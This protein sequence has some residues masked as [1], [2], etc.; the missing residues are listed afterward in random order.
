MSLQ[1]L[2][3]AALLVGGIA[4]LTVVAT[5]PLAFTGP[6]ALDSPGLPARSEAAPA[7]AQGR[8]DLRIH[9][10]D[11]SATVRV[12]VTSAER[13]T[14]FAEDADLP[15][16]GTW[17]RTLEVVPAAYEV[18]VR[19]LRGS[20]AGG[21]DLRYCPDFHA[22]SELWVRLPAQGLI[23]AS[24][25]GQS[26]VCADGSPAYEPVP[27]DEPTR[28]AG[29]ATVMFGTHGVGT[30]C[31]LQDCSFNWLSGSLGFDLV[32]ASRLDV[33]AWWVPTTPA[34]ER[35]AVGVYPRDGGGWGAEGV[36]EVVFTVD[37]AE[38]GD[39]W[40]TAWATGE[41]VG[42]QVAQEV[43]VEVLMTPLEA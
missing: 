17:E 12:T 42:A 2:A 18:E 36:R 24:F 1:V 7:E 10:E 27:E 31:V 39:Y 15:P 20:A 4:V 30:V 41:P 32:R 14:V 9:N 34:S 37:L 40:M 25:R 22:I 6:W 33:R 3:V 26:L 8:L 13:Q 43:N 38:P 35:L 23:D 11:E 5:A 21:G 19:H 29:K 16:R 28:F